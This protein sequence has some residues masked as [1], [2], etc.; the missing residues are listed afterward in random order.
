MPNQTDETRRE[1]FTR[2]FTN[3]RG[4]EYLSNCQPKKGMGIDEF[5]LYLMRL[6]P[7]RVKLQ[8]IYIV[9]ELVIQRQYPK[10]WTE[11]IAL[12]VS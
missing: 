1:Y 5:D 6:A 10:E 3:E 4:L 12:L 9:R 8:F 2:I 7:E 11:W